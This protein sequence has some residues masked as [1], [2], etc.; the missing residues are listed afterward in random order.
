MQHFLKANPDHFDSLCTGEQKCSIRKNDRN[1]QVGDEVIFM[2]YDNV[3]E[4][5]T[6]DSHLLHIS[7]IEN[8]GVHQG[9]VVL[10]LS[11]SSLS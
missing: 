2:E 4:R 5:C 1:F 7:H 3:A 10:S 8:F 11:L 6:G 9:Y